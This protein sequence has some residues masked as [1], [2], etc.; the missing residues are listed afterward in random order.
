MSQRKAALIDF[1]DALP[2]LIFAPPDVA[3][4]GLW[5]L[6]HKLPQCLRLVKVEPVPPAAPFVSR[7]DFR[8]FIDTLTHFGGLSFFVMLFDCPD[9]VGVGQ[10]PADARDLA[11]SALPAHP[12]DVAG[13]VVRDV[14]ERTLRRSG[15]GR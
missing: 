9:Q 1:K 6:T 2:G 5:M 11:R 14:L 8:H 15:T 7:H 4:F 12:G 3:R 10:L 13:G